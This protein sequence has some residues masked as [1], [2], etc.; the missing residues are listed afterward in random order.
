MRHPHVTSVVVMLV[1]AGGL[2]AACRTP[3]EPATALGAT[4]TVHTPVPTAAGAPPTASPPPDATATDELAPT[5]TR[6]ELCNAGGGGTMSVAAGRTQDAAVLRADSWIAIGGITELAWASHWIVQGRVAAQCPD[7]DLGYPEY[8]FEIERTFR[9]VS[10]S[11]MIVQ[12]IGD[13]YGAPP[14]PAVGDELVLFVDDD[15]WVVGGPQG[16]FYIDDGLVGAEYGYVA[17]PL[18]EFGPAIAAA[19]SGAPPEYMPVP[20]V[21]LETSPPGPE[22]PAPGATL[23]AGCGGALT[24]MA[25]QGYA[26]YRLL[27]NSHQVFAGTVVEQLASVQAGS[28]EPETDPLLRPVVTDYLVQIEQPIRGLPDEVVRVRR[29]G[30][31]LAGCSVANVEG[32][33]LAAGQRVLMFA[34][35]PEPDS[36]DPTYYLSG[37]QSGVWH[38][39]DEEALVVQHGVVYGAPTIVPMQSFVA[40][41]LASLA[42]APPE[43]DGSALGF[44]PID[45]AP[46]GAAVDWPAL[47]PDETLEWVTSR[48]EAFGLTVTFPE[49][50]ASYDDVPA[51]IFSIATYPTS[52]GAWE[53]IPEGGLRIDVGRVWRPDFEPQTPLVIG[54][55]RMPGS[56]HFNGLIGDTYHAYITYEAAGE[57]WQLAGYFKEPADLNN[58]NLRLFF[59]I[60][61]S[62]AHGH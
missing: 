40:G 39:A 34:W 57:R 7:G 22:L 61:M 43:D 31:E 38:F 47:P 26:A 12:G 18:E 14:P 24:P 58:P 36:T 13:R 10:R 46:A 30:G 28:P 4:S 55:H 33:L 19:L 60:V 23:P 49:S 27:W 8:A 15:G 16:T 37:S 53:S 20:A 1:L 50:W 17:L 41:L 2:L 35:T 9:G 48:H 62:I 11:V 5:I 52:G 29:L 51:G 56:I 45:A 3:D 44:V 54:P 42:A 6:E 21:P 59:A 25:A 32:Q